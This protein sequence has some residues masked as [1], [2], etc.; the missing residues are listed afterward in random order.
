MEI[1]FWISL[2]ILLYVYIGYGAIVS[3]ALKLKKRKEKFVLTPDQLP[4]CTHIIAAYNETP[5]LRA[6]IL[7]TL[8]LNYPE[9]KQQIII[10]TDGSTDNPQIGRAHV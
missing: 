3:L 5:L 9:G 10:V 4:A 6:K 8:A 2:T 1:I 7:N